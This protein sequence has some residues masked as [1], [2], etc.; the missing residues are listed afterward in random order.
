MPKR[1]VDAAT[2]L[3]ARKG[4]YGTSIAALADAAGLTKGALYHHF[5]SKDAIFFA[6]VESVRT[7]WDQGVA[8]S[9]LHGP[10][11]ATQL[12]LLLDHHTRLLTENEMLCLVMSNLML[13]MENVNPAYATVLQQ[14]YEDLT[15]FIERIIQNGQA[16]GAIR[17]DIDPRLAA[18]N[19]VGMLKGIGCN[20]ALGRMG[21]D[22]RAMTDTLKQ[23]LLDGLRA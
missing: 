13:E 23:M 17:A 9:V 3:F 22:R 6:V 10:D 14:V 5:E 8:R 4:F 19:I 12:E 15:V 16:A 11:A 18:I 7:L 20:P 2:R 21:T 1:I